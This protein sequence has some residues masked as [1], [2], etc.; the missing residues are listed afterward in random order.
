MI[1]MS[2]MKEQISIKDFKKLDVR[3][4]TI[5]EVEKVSGSD[6][7]LKM[8]VDLGEETRQIVA[9]LAE[10]YSNEEM[11]GK[12]IAVLINLKPAKIFGQFSYGMLLAA[13]KNG[14][15]S[16]LTVDREIQNGAIIT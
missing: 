3:I 10:Y 7:L 5:T 15:L 4:G 13:E 16:I 11:K 6:K 8:Q 2:N 12:K 9:G 1:I 14:K